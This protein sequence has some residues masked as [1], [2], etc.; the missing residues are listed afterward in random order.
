MLLLP[1]AG[2]DV[3]SVQ[4]GGAPELHV[5]LPRDPRRLQLVELASDRALLRSVAA[6]RRQRQHD[7]LLRDARLSRRQLRQPRRIRSQ[8]GLR[9]TR[10]ASPLFLFSHVQYSNVDARY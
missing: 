9:T 6:E 4:T 8:L 2:V 7:A 5:G 3:Q 1:V 10:S